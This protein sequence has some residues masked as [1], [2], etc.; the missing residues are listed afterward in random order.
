VKEAVLLATAPAA[1]GGAAA[2]QP[3]EDTTLLGRMLDQLE[4][5]GVREAHVLTRPDFADGLACTRARVHVCDDVADDLRTLAGIARDGDGGVVLAGAEILTQRELLAGLLADARVPTGIV[6]SGGRTGR[7]FGFR[8]RAERGRIVSAGSL[9]HSVYTP[10]GSFLGVLKI[11]AADRPA[12][13]DAAGRMAEL[14]GGPR[15]DGWEAALADKTRR[16][17]FAL[18]RRALAEGEEPEESREA[19]S[20][21]AFA[22]ELAA[23]EPPPI[24]AGAVQLS[25]ADEVELKLR[26]TAARDDV[27]AFV[28][29]ALVRGDVQIGITRVR[30]LFWARPL[31][32]AILARAAER[33]DEHDEEK[34]LL[35]STVKANDGFFTTHFV[36]P[37]SKYIARWAARRGWTPNGVTTLSVVTGFL[38]AAAFAT[39][40]RLGLVAG[41]VL[42]QLAFT[43]DCVDGQ[44]ARYTRTFTKFGAWL[45]AIF[46]RIKEYAVFA[47]L[48]IGAARSGHDVWLLAGA[49]LTL[50]TARHAVEFSYPAALAQT[51][52]AIRH[53]PLERSED[54]FGPVA[55]AV[56]TGDAPA[57]PP[58]LRAR[59]IRGWRALDRA[60]RARWLKK[61]IAFPI[62]ERFAA[63]SLSAA[64]FDARVTFIVLLAWGGVGALYTIT[65]RVLRSVGIR[66]AT[67]VAPGAGAGT[68]AL[69]V[70][71]D[72]G[73]LARALGR[74][75]APDVAPIALVAA[76]LLPLLATMAIAGD[77]A[78]W[79][80][81]GA[82]VAWFVLAAGVS[83]G[84]I[85][86]DRLRWMV[87][88]ALRLGEYAG[89]L[90]IAA[91]A[92]SSVV[93]AAFALLCALMF[94][95]YDLGYRLRHRGVIP[96]AWVNAVAGGW[97]GRLVAGTALAVAGLVPA[98]FYAAAG[99]YAVL[100][101]GESGAGWG[102][103][104]RT[105]RPPAYEDDEEDEA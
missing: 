86:R 104:S 45:D 36:S 26:V 29:V 13:A 58:S 82:A 69:V 81:A 74:L 70:Y 94:R 23:A 99:L 39:G 30:S 27:T 18:H 17:R 47:G 53:A 96:P 67:P 38:S 103:L 41:A 101:V 20:D 72:D 60:P 61:M 7:R 40:D 92:A 63:I 98:A 85:M 42:L 3:W 73:P 66:G 19:V 52:H 65:G 4:S 6:V 59:V 56:R 93:P 64:L 21:E 25:P 10:N 68:F 84:R 44:L 35:D 8:V 76:G 102:S 15:P 50:Q 28:L 16:W 24:D 51:A 75:P 55:S 37:Y 95:H 80:L 105:Q 1:G 77:G 32:P 34:A 43:F 11:A 83:S 62:G 79:P 14:T 89:L 5:L 33:I 57:P 2:A 54:G 87:A 91:L 100:F 31:T 88:P 46:D 49:A 12:L 22:D 9:Y 97:D 78:S 90:W 48:A 71:R